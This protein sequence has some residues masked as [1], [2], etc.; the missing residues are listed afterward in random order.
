MLKNRSVS[1]HRPS[2]LQSQQIQ[3][4]GEFEGIFSFQFH[5]QFLLKKQNDNYFLK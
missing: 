2:R 1:Y 5:R 4:F 3:T